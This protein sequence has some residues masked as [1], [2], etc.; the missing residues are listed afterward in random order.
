MPDEDKL[1]ERRRAH[2]LAHRV[3]AFLRENW[4]WEIR[5]L[6]LR[7]DLRARLSVGF[8]RKIVGAVIWDRNLICIDPSYDDFFGVLIHECLH[9]LY[10]QM[11]EAGI[12]DLERIVRL[13]LTPAQAS[14]LLI[15]AARRLR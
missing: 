15:E 6:P 11:E 9:C 4:E 5:F 8:T 14:S 2:R 13:H 12:R 3:I 1:R 10:P 7:S